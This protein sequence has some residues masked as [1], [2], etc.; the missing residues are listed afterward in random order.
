MYFQKIL[1]LLSNY[2]YFSSVKQPFPISL[3]HLL[4]LASDKHHF[5]FN[6]YEIQLFWVPHT[7]DIT[8]YLM[9]LIYFT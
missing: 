1:L 9:C 4:K 3:T 8:L 6:F 5:T 7:T 2:T